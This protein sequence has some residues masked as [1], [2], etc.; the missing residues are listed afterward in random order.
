MVK[1]EN[2]AKSQTVRNRSIALMTP[3][4]TRETAIIMTLQ[5]E[6]WFPIHDM[7]RSPTLFVSSAFGQ[8]LPVVRANRLT[9]N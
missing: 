1:Q 8:F 3:P 4:H 9:S 7:L 6:N 5:Q 2:R